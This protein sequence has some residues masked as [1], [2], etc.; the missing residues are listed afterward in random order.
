MIP[1]L[2]AATVAVPGSCPIAVAA[3]A[4][5]AFVSDAHRAHAAM[6]YAVA[7]RATRDPELA[8]DV[9]QEAF[10][11]LL[12]EARAGRYADSTGVW[13]YRTVSNLII[14]R[15]RRAE[16]ARR[17]APRLLE[18]GAPD[19]P[20]AV[21]VRREGQA[22]V[23]MALAALS[24]DER[25]ALL[26]AAGG[27]TGVEIASSL[28]RSHGATRA[29]MCRARSRLRAGALAATA[30]GDTT[31][32]TAAAAPAAP[33]ASVAPRVPV[34]RRTVPMGAVLMGW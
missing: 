15:A 33:A 17:Y 22:E 34:R 30:M 10:I 29:L 5:D 1:M 28:G 4:P 14:S 31:A 6:T 27:A 18:L 13:L 19:Q 24:R 25:A 11:K 3:V 8:E 2:Q 23:R 7:M 9:T 26:L 21:A 12:I 16:V 32:A 20:E